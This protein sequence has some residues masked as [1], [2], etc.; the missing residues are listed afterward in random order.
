MYR[1]KVEAAKS[2]KIA[3]AIPRGARS[4]L[5]AYLRFYFTIKELNG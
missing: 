1:K 2:I 5:F 4:N 3:P